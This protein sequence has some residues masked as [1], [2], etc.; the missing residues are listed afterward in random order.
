MCNIGESW[1]SCLY[2]S[3]IMTKAT[4][5]LYIERNLIV[6][7]YT[8]NSHTANDIHTHVSYDI[9]EQKITYYHKQGVTMFRYM[10][11]YWKAKKPQ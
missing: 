4:I 2:P 9:I 3:R 5:L 7:A 6:H 1:K 8:Y 10:C 11:K